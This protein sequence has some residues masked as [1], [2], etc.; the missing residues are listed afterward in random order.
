MELRKAYIQCERKKSEREIEIE[1]KRLEKWEI[2]PEE[3]R[4]LVEYIQRNLELKI[5]HLII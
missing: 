2:T 1:K 4:K 5:L 3:H